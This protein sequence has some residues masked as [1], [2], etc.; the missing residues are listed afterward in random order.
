MMNRGYEAGNL[1]WARDLRRSQQYQGPRSKLEQG[2]GEETGT[3]SER[4]AKA[5]GSEG[6]SHA[7][8]T[9]GPIIQGAT[10]T[11][12]AYVRVLGTVGPIISVIVF[13][14]ISHQES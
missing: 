9:A 12:G 2:Y 6:S 1:G 11:K 13:V 10:P 3:M 7:D 5:C 8:L 14:T 4:G